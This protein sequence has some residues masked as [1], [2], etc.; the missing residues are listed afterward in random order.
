MNGFF[1]APSFWEW[2]R[3]AKLLIDFLVIA[4]AVAIVDFV[5]FPGVLGSLFS[6][7]PRDLTALPNIL[8]RPF[9]HSDWGHLMG[10]STA[11]LVFGGM[12]VLRDA[13]DL[14]IVSLT[15]AFGS[16]LALWL[17]GRPS[18]YRGAS[19]MIFGYVG[20]LLT[21]IYLYKDPWAVV[22]FCVILLSFF[23]G[24][25]LVMP[26]VTGDRGWSFGRS[27]WLIL[28][29]PSGRIAWEGHL[30]GFLAGIWTAMRLNDLHLFFKPFFDWLPTVI[31]WVE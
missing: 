24:D 4:W 23:F 18:N 13:S 20:F 28:P 19:S 27:L 7:R 5:V 31:Q 2:F 3:Q 12:I 30:F 8:L 6:L 21:L 11:F 26:A 15:T 17:V 1:T 10:N 16:G 14:A 22:F 9:L 25:L 29:T